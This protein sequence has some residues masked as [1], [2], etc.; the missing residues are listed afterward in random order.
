MRLRLF[1]RRTSI[2]LRAIKLSWVVSIITIIV[3]AFS[4]IPL[5]RVSLLDS[6]RSTAQLVSTSVSEVAAGAI[7]V[8]D[9]SSAVDHCLKI[10]KNGESVR[11]IVITRNDGYS[12]IHKPD[13][14]STAQLSG[15]W[16]PP[17]PRASRGEIVQTEMARERI[18]LYSTPLNY[19]GFDWGWIHIGLS[20]EKFDQD[21]RGVYRRT[22]LLGVACILLGLGAT[23]FYAKRLVRPIRTLTEITRRV[24]A[25]DFAAQAEIR[26]GDEVEDLGISFNSMTETLQNALEELKAARD[27]TQ[28]IIQ[29]M[30]D[31][32]LV[33]S[34]EGNIVT[35]NPATCELLQ[36]SARRHHWPVKWLLSPRFWPVLQSFY[37]KETKV[38]GGAIS[39]RT[40]IRFSPGKLNQKARRS[41]KVHHAAIGE[42]LIFVRHAECLRTYLVISWAE[43]YFD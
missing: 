6:L 15:K 22:V 14:W 11:F 18:Y 30:N 5:Q 7:V 21:V 28:N 40:I 9:Y 36:C 3:F 35:V 29:S 34:P 42:M 13:G 38:L 20:L 24:A 25:G 10:V 16:R 26:S 2:L 41:R 4:I 39:F 33:C 31:L 12:L 1:S 37:R 32:L 19:S 27:Y 23:V 8:E 43:L 17:G